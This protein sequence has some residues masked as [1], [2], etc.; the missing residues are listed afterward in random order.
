M[1][2]WGRMTNL[3]TAKSVSR[4]NGRLLKGPGGPVG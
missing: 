3:Y 2:L 1:V 4:A